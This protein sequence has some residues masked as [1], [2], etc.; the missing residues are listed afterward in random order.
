MPEPDGSSEPRA[1][2]RYDQVQSDVLQLKARLPQEAVGDIVREVLTR[3]TAE[4]R[5]NRDPVNQPSRRKVESLCYAL[6]S[7]D[8]GEGAAFVQEVKDDGAALE[9]IYLNYL[10]EA[11]AILGEW[12]DDDH[13]SFHEVTIASS[14]IYAILREYSYLFVPHHPVEVKSAIFATVPGEIHTLGVHMAADL[15]GQDG[16]NVDVLTGRSHEELMADITASPCR[17]LGLSAGGVHS[18]AALARLVMA[19]RVSR[20]DLRIVLSGQITRV[21]ADLVAMMGLDG[22]AADMPEAQRT[23]ED[24]WSDLSAPV[25]PT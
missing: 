8:P 24:L 21:A 18:A 25:G 22:V 3:V 7:D 4:R 23:L 5:T 9:S 20:P 13:V 14:R 11:A 19:L 16:W 17:I 12:W 2:G 10:A 1:F 6:I 15:F